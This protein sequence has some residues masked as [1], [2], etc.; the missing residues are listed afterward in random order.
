MLSDHTHISEIIYRRKKIAKLMPTSL[1]VTMTTA[2]KKPLAG[3]V[4]CVIIRMPCSILFVDL[5][6]THQMSDRRQEEQNQYCLK[7]HT[8]HGSSMNRHNS[9]I[10]IKNN[11]KSTHSEHQHVVV[12]ATLTK[13]GM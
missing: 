9:D 13:K 8:D 7:S 2:H 1:P 3:T 5:P 12:M 11:D 10:L 6:L 4:C